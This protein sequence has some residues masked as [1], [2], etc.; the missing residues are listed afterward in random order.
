MLATILGTGKLKSD[1][2]CLYR[3]IIQI[4][5]CAVKIQSENLF[6]WEVDCARESHKT[7]T[8]NQNLSDQG[9]F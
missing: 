9:S 3:T 6:C 7:I 8:T 2:C 5:K 4:H 1:A